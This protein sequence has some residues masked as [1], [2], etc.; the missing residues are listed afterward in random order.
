MRLQAGGQAGRRAGRRP[1]G[2]RSR[3]RRGRCSS[4]RGR[5]RTSP[6]RRKRRARFS[7]TRRRSS[8][9]RTACRANGDGGFHLTPDPGRLLHVVR[10]TTAGSSPT[11]ATTIRATPATSSRRWRRRR[12]A[13]RKI[14]ELFADELD[15]LDPGGQAERDRALDARS[16]R[17]STTSSSPRV[18]D[19][20]RLTPTIVEVIVKAPAAARHF[21]P[22]Q[23]YRLQNYETVG[24]RGSSGASRC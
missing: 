24:A 22:G 12:T 18:E 1:A 8:S 2:E 3:C 14:V 4:R 21:Q 13:I 9:S 16:S 11:T 7:S 19:V 6:T 17:G 20:V 5:R 23:F 15:A 10:R